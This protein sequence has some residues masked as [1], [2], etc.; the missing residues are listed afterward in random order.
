MTQHLVSKN[1]KAPI[2]WGLD[3]CKGRMQYLMRDYQM[4]RDSTRFLRT[5]NSHLFLVP[6]GRAIRPCLWLVGSVNNRQPMRPRLPTVGRQQAARSV[7][8]GPRKGAGETLN[9]ASSGVAP[10]AMHPHDLAKAESV[11][12]SPEAIHESHES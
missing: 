9:E 11:R 6:V 5:V 7:S 1:D 10:E 12:S 2:S 8:S 3:A 4:G